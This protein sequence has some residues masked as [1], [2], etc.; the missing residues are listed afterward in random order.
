VA[1]VDMIETDFRRIGYCANPDSINDPAQSIVSVTANSISFLTDVNKDGVVDKVQYSVSG[2]SALLSTPNPRDMLLFRKVNNEPA[3]GM[4]IGVTKFEL[5]YLDNNGNSIPLPI[6]YLGGIQSVQLS[7]ELENPFPYDT[8][9]T[10]AYWRQL[11]L[12]SRNFNNR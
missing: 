2:T 8:V 7:L 9:N 1:V 11:R 4:S 6:V 3:K 12:Q 5:I 10:F